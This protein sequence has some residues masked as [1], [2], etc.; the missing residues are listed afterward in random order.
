MKIKLIA[1][2]LLSVIIIWVSYVFLGHKTTPK[3]GK[4][5]TNNTTSSPGN[6]PSLNQDD[7][8]ETEENN[9]LN[10]EEQYS[11]SRKL[12]QKPLPPLNN[13]DKIRWAFRMAETNTFL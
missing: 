11:I 1:A 6:I 5:D 10:I 12:Y 2:L 8:S 4:P 3:P 13:R 7:R 9:F